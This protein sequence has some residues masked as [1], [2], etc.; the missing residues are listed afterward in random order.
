MPMKHFSRVT[1]LFCITMLV[2]IMMTSLFVFPV[3]AVSSTEKIRVGFFPF[4]GFNDFG[5]NGELSGYGYEYLME[6][7]KYTGWQ[8]E[9]ITE[10]TEFDGQKK[11]LSY[12]RALAMLEAG[13]IDI[14]GAVRKKSGRDSALFFPELPA[15]TNVGIL[16]VPSYND[17]ATSENLNTLNKLKIGLLKGNSRNQEIINY[18]E[19]QKIKGCTFYE[20]ESLDELKIALFITHEVTAIYTSNLRRLEKERIVLRLNPSPYYFVMKKDDPRSEDLQVAQETISLLTPSF[21]NVLSDRYYE[22]G[23]AQIF[24]LTEEEREYI[25]NNSTIKVGIDC[26]YI[27]I[28]YCDPKTGEYQGIVADIMRSVQEKTGF[29]FQYIPVNQ[30]ELK[31][32]G[33][34]IDMIASVGDDYRW[35]TKHN[36]RLT[37]AYLNLSLSAVFHENVSD[38]DNPNHTVALVKNYYLSELVQRK[39]PYINFLWV[40]SL[41]DCVEAINKGQAQVAFM[42]TFS[43]DYFR[44]KADY[45]HINSAIAN[46]FSYSLSI[47]VNENADPMLYLILNK[48]LSSIPSSSIDQAVY[49]NILSRPKEDALS[50]LIFKYP[51]LII[52]LLSGV[53]LFSLLV[54]GLLYR[55]KTRSKSEKRINEERIQIALSETN[56][57]IW[58]YD[59]F[60]RMIVQTPA[61]L[62]R[63][64]LPETMTEFPPEKLVKCEFIHPDFAEEYLSLFSEISS[65]NRTSANVRIQIIQDGI[66]TRNFRWEHIALTSIYD[67]KGIMVQAVGVCEDITDMMET[68]CELHK[69]AQYQEVTI[70]DALLLLEVD[71]TLG[72][73]LKHRKMLQHSV[74]LLN[75]DFDYLVEYVAK[76]HIYPEDIPS[77][78]KF[79][80]RK[81]ILARF[82]KG[83]CEQQVEAR[84]RLEK[85]K[86]VYVVCLMH[87]ILDPISGH[88]CATLTMKNVDDRKRYELELKK[89]ATED[90]LTGLSNRVVL[91]EA[92]NRILRENGGIH[93]MLMMD[94]DNFKRANDC[95]GHMYGDEVLMEI[96]RILRDSF[97]SED[98][99]AR[100]GGDEFIILMRNIS[101]V[102]QACE[103]ANSL[104]NKIS[105]KKEQNLIT[106]SIGIAVS[107]QHGMTFDNLYAAADQALYT[108]KYSGKARYF[109][110]Q[111]ESI[112]EQKTLDMAEK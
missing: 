70:A 74:E 47:G 51:K 15:G 88:I 56:V 75:K 34:T 42:P 10:M 44:R 62:K 11:P 32:S 5:E 19:K 43:A 48:V 76:N 66:W 86:Y 104:C 87:L 85:D 83:E 59:V 94:L 103:K 79:F 108:A 2:F 100:M 41:E 29:K 63:W 109:L 61:S 30:N 27:P 71:I 35:A 93:A 28:E 25:R 95:F 49:N 73:I 21:A 40:D 36:I 80:L 111:G 23:N 68:Q 54:L 55:Q 72:K 17:V 14:M 6:I 8:Y 46:D 60:R 50:V 18:I 9:F 110:Y 112:E 101:S 39:Y 33:E 24:M 98:I 69:V 31:N 16:T 99:V 20:Y 82:A 3:T 91:K 45:T 64:G 52:G 12:E 89:R 107:P 57:T 97:R 67:E 26:G 22:S 90:Q 65:V 38:Y 78:Q 77:Y 7:S 1:F 105:F 13:E 4:D 102:N 37:P 84:V 58:D 96:G 92:T 53:W 106:C 81:N